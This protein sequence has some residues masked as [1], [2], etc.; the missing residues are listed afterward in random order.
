M[1][2]FRIGRRGIATFTAAALMAGIAVSAPGGVRA[3]GYSKASLKGTYIF[4]ASGVGLFSA[5]NQPSAGPV[6]AAG[7]G[8]VTFDGEGHFTGTQT[9]SSTP[10]QGVP[11]PGPKR[12][13]GEKANPVQVTCT[14]KVTGTYDVSADGGT[15]SS[16]SSTPTSKENCAG[17]DFTTSGVVG[18]GGR[19]LYGVVTGVTVSDTSQGVFASNVVEFELTRQ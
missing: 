1:D 16:F 3:A 7:L 19:V 18:S 2:L 17:A 4:H 12:A 8:M 14:Y 6:F 13:T 11:T 5:P 15:T 9:V 10:M